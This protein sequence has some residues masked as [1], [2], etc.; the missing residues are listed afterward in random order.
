MCPNG[1]TKACQNKK[2]IKPFFEH[3]YGKRPREEL[4]DLS[5]D[6]HQMNNVVEDEDYAGIAAE[7]RERLMQELEST[8]DPRLVDDGK[9]FETPPMAGPWVNERKKKKGKK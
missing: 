1:Q 4:F 7:L 2:R 5:R 3:A 8:N 9:F 6:P